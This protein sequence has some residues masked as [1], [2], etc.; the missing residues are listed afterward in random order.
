MNLK[1]ILYGGTESSSSAANFGL[2]ILRVY[3]GL[4]LALAHGINKFPPSARFIDGV[5]DLGFPA[6]ILFAWLASLSELLGGFLLALG[7]FTRPS[8]LMIA[9]TMA[10]AGFMQHGNDPFA[11]QEKALLFLAISIA[12]LFIGAGKFSID[13]AVR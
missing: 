3:T 5:G 13:K 6:P 9:G 8:A 1:S 2:L 11:T 12:F 4:S 7:L 10:V